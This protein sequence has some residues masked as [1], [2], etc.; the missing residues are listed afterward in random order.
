M[1]YLSWY[2]KSRF[3]TKHLGGV[4]VQSSAC[5]NFGVSCGFCIFSVEFKVYA[6]AH[7]FVLVHILPPMNSAFELTSYVQYAFLKEKR[8]LV[9]RADILGILNGLNVMDRVVPSAV[10]VNFRHRFFCLLEATAETSTLASRGHV[11]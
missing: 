6:Y 5:V 10:V 2:L 9:E 8:S 7:A 3:G 11:S 4:I 1:M